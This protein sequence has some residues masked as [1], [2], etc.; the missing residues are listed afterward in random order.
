MKR[1]RIQISRMN[2]NRDEQMA[3]LELRMTSALA[4]RMEAS[5]F[6]RSEQFPR[7]EDW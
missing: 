6:K 3:F 7:L 4:N 1:E 2:G 5:P